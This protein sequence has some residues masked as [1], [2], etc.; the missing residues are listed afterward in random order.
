MHTQI[1]VYR[2]RHVHVMHTHIHTHNNKAL[3]GKNG[4]EDR[5]KGKTNKR[6][7]IKRN[8]DQLNKLKCP[9][10]RN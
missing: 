7:V 6:T 4:S 10:S 8:I 2:F 3:W 1:Y 9:E 5:T